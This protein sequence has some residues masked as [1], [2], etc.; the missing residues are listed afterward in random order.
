MHCRGQ[1]GLFDPYDIM[2]SFLGALFSIMLA[3]ILFL[4]PRKSEMTIEQSAAPNGGS[5]TQLDRSD[6][7]DGPP[8]TS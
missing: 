1:Y 6:V 8:S 7:T 4:M 2:A 5:A 3:S